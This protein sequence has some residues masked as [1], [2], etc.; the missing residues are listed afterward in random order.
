MFGLERNW[1][2]SVRETDLPFEE[3]ILIEPDLAALLGECMVSLHGQALP[4]RLVGASSAGYGTEINSVRYKLRR[5][6]PPS[7]ETGLAGESGS[8]SVVV[9]PQVEFDDS[10]GGQDDDQDGPEEYSKSFQV[11]G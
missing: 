11:L 9:G 8:L 6:P 4:C 10:K 3:G 5:K 1:R 2:R 7:H